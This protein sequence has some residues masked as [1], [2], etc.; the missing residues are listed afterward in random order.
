MDKVYRT[1]VGEQ[2][3]ITLADDSQVLLNTDSLIEVTYREHY[4]L[5]EL[6]R[7][8]IHIQVAHDP[9]RPL[10]VV[11]A[12][13]VIRA[14]GTAFNV[15]LLDDSRVELIVTEGTV[16]V[17]DTTFNESTSNPVEPLPL[18]KVAES[19][20][21]TRGG[22]V[23]LGEAKETVRQIKQNEIDLE[24]SWRQGNIV[25]RGEPLEAVIAEISRYTSIEFE[26]TNEAIKQVRV[27]GM[28]KAG[29]VSGLLKALDKSF[30]IKSHYVDKEKV[31]LDINPSTVNQ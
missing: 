6:K 23:L 22:K 11:A 19:V 24:L 1:T 26:F 20:D 14:I 27:A 18:E 31:V 12:G 29:D 5:I 28:F 8:E 25:F 16:R 15:Q 17:A 9:N 30:D 21:I 4:R 7:G 10:S 2:L 3:T 13:K